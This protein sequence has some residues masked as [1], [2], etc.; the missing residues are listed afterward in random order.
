MGV[1]AKEQFAEQ[2]SGCDSGYY[3]S[4][5]SQSK[6]KK[7]QMHCAVRTVLRAALK[8]DEYYERPAYDQTCRC[9]SEM[10]SKATDK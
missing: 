9:T 1:K 4:T 10:K 7:K 5:S 3:F 6:S 8:R 2:D